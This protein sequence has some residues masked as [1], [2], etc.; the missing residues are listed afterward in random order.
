MNITIMGSRYDNL[1]ATL[2]GYLKTGVPLVSWNGTQFTPVATGDDR[3]MAYFVPQIAALTHSDTRHAI[4]LFCIGTM[5]LALLCGLC[6]CLFLFKSAPQRGIAFLGLLWLARI[7]LGVGDVYLFPVALTLALIPF[8]LW[9]L[10]RNKAT[11]AFGAFLFTA[12]MAIS[13]CNWIRS[14]GG[15]ATVVFMAILLLAGLT[16]PLKS[17]VLLLLCL[18][19]GMPIP[20]LLTRAIE[21]RAE[22]Y[23]VAHQPG[24]QPLIRQHV[25]W[26]SVY[27]GFGYLNNDFGLTYHDQV[28][29][30]KVASIDPTVPYCSAEYERIL[31]RATFQFVRAH[32]AFALDTLAA[33]AGVLLFFLIRYANIG[34]IAAWRSRRPRA[35]DAAFGAA[36]AVGVLPGLLVVPVPSYVTSFAAFAV[37]YA[38]VCLNM[39][40][41]SGEILR[42]KQKAPAQEGII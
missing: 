36:M 38:V 16:A 10:K 34:L 30:A 31:K 14:Q 12:G 21:N 25:L 5:L 41:E 39:A 33:K 15:M 37:L 27:I 32:P 2:A 7:G 29:A 23:M 28:A 40:L 9:F 3:G 19:A 24:Y 4:N 42:R 35:W 22:A 6:G 8:F 17:R 11:P 20:V 13:T 1:V 26:H 18:F